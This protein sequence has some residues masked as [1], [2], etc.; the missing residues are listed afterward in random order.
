MNHTIEFDIG[1]DV[2]CSDGPC[3]ELTRV[4]VDPVAVAITHLVVE[5]KHRHGSGHLVPIALASLED[6]VIQLRC[7]SSEFQ[8]LEEA[9][10]TQLLFGA[11]APWVT[12]RIRCFRS[13]T[14]A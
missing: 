10:E 11:G 3:G 7:T 13:R 1:S 2:T 5:A 9:G 14:T 8:A 6:D 12:S 4:V